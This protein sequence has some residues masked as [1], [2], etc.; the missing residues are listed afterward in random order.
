MRN[1]QHLHHE[2]KVL[3]EGFTQPY[4]SWMNGSRLV[5]RLKSY[6]WTDKGGVK[7]LVWCQKCLWGLLSTP[8]DLR[9]LSQYSP[10]Y[11][12]QRCSSYSF[13]IPISKDVVHLA[14]EILYYLTIKHNSI[15]TI[16]HDNV[17]SRSKIVYRLWNHKFMLGFHSPQNQ[18]HPSGCRN[19]SHKQEFCGGSVTSELDCGWCWKGHPLPEAGSNY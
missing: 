2:L 7:T 4:W 14:A 9:I 6:F 10:W 13:Q 19:S 8:S 12:S 17:R 1:S 11:L 16:K 3:T 5:D 15:V 18:C